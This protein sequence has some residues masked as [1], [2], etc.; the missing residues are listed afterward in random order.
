MKLSFESYRKFL[1]YIGYGYNTTNLKTLKNSLEYLN[2]LRITY[3]ADSPGE[4]AL[5]PPIK[6]L[7][8][9]ATR[10]SDDLI[11]I[12]L[13]EEFYN[14]ATKTPTCRAPLPLLKDAAAQNL[15]MLMFASYWFD[16]EMEEGENFKKR[17]RPIPLNVIRR[18]VGLTTLR[19]SKQLQAA[20]FK[21]EDLYEAHGGKIFCVLIDGMFDPALWKGMQFGKPEKA[22]KPAEPKKVSA[23]HVPE[24]KTYLDV[25]YA[26]IAK[27]KARGAYW[28]ITQKKWYVPEG[29][30]ILKFTRWIEK[31]AK[32]KTSLW[33]KEFAAT[34]DGRAEIWV[35]KETGET[36]NADPR[37]I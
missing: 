14:Y 8:L 37:T 17:Q 15:S 35:N 36:R 31:P 6:Q 16:G 7:K 24:K 21:V 25:P 13:N 3:K 9:P 10:S 32:K 11:V 23:P 12:E 2:N 18:K 20:A 28:D 5:P 29:K 19:C 26:D 30:S 4:H 22:T 1:T 34:D 33:K 27:A